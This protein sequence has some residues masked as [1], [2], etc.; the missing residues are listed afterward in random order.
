MAGMS[1]VVAP[2]VASSL[3][4]NLT[5]HDLPEAPEA[6][7]KSAPQAEKIHPQR[8]NRTGTPEMIPSSRRTAPAVDSALDDFHSRGIF[9]VD[10]GKDRD[11]SVSTSG[12]PWVRGYTRRLIVGDVMVVAWAA[13]G[14]HMVHLGSLTSRV[15]R[16]AES[17]PFIALTGCLAIGWMI[18]LHWGGTRDA[19]VVGYGPEEYKRLVNTSVGLFGLIAICSYVFDLHLPRAYVLVT[20]PAG[21]V[22]LVVSRFI[23]RRWLQVQRLKGRSMSKVLV[24]GNIRTVKELLLD[25]KRAPEAGYRVL[26]VCVQSASTGR[27]DGFVDGIPVLGGLQNI[28]STALR[29]G[30][31]TVAVTSTA[32]FGPAAVRR[33]SW[34]LEKTDIQLVLA[35]ALTNIAGPRI[36]TQPVAGLPLIHVDRP[37]YR[38]AN[39]I[40]KKTFDFAGSAMLLLVFSPLL[41]GVAI[42]VKISGPGP[43]FFRQQRA[44]INGKTFRMIKFRSMVIDAEARLADLRELQTDAGNE[45]LFKMQN[46]PRVTRI[47]RV[48]RRL[49]LDELPQLINVLKGDMSLVGPRPP[50]L[51]E[52]ATYQGEARLRMLVRPGMTGLWQV[53][54]RSALS[55]EDSV[56]LDTYYVENWSL[57]SD[58]LI[59]WRTAKAVRSSS[60]AY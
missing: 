38:G 50:L 60:G 36:H 37:T 32:T 28:T 16:D 31:D 27:G 48:L 11:L 29:F 53:S 12:K 22:G 26:G 1:R 6:S 10:P 19:E 52:I 24:V 17:L 30:A 47:G 46:D 54:G 44:G 14:A 33:L 42:A 8:S 23:W 49:S 57:V 35:P 40:L 34:E 58:L 9:P 7:Q 21:L 15:S 39:R 18:A 13:T 45:V 41:L 59:L 55:W 2:F 56:R 20:L 3:R 4:E 43:I 25:L 5:G 51:D